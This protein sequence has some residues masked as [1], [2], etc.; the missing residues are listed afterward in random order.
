AYDT[1]ILVIATDWPRCVAADPR[2]AQTATPVCRR[3]CAVFGS[4]GYERRPI[5][6]SGGICRISLFDPDHGGLVHPVRG[7]CIDGPNGDYC[8][9]RPWRRRVEQTGVA[10]ALP[11]WIF[12]CSPEWGRKD[13]AGSPHLGEKRIFPL[14]MRLFRLRSA[15]EKGIFRK[16][17]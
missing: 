17:A 16:Y 4:A 11:A 12:G 14:L 5:A 6:R 10:F 8:L 15:S 13:F 2:R 7:R 1:I 9:C 3:L